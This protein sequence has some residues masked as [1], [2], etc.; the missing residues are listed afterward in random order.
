MNTSSRFS[1]KKRGSFLSVQ[2]V[3][4]LL[5]LLLSILVCGLLLSACDPG[6]N[7]NVSCS[8]NNISCNNSNN[9]SS[10]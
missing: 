1:H 4:V 6:I 10:P 8:G 2:H 9:N 7:V 5:L 3:G